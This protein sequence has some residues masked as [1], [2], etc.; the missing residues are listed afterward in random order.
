MLG[1]VLMLA[2]LS[3]AALSIESQS[4][5]VYSVSQVASSHCTN[6]ITSYG[7]TVCT[8]A[9]MQALGEE[10]V[11]GKRDEGR[12]GFR[13]N[14]ELY[15]EMTC[16][17][18]N[19]FVLHMTHDGKPG[20]MYYADASGNILNI[21]QPQ[22]NANSTNPTKT[23]ATKY[24][25]ERH[26][27]ATADTKRGIK[28]WQCH[29]I[30]CRPNATTG[31]MRC[32][33]ASAL[34]KDYTPLSIGDSVNGS[35]TNPDSLG[36]SQTGG[37]PSVLTNP[38]TSEEEK[39]RIAMNLDESTK[40]AWGKAY[41]NED[42]VLVESEK[43]KREE[44]DAAQEALNKL[45]H[46]AQGTACG[47]PNAI[48]DAELDLLR[49]KE[50]LQQIEEQ[51]KRLENAQKFLIPEGV[52][53][54]EEQGYF[55]EYGCDRRLDSISYRLCVNS[56]QP[57]ERGLRLGYGSDDLAY[58]SFGTAYSG[59]SRSEL[60]DACRRRDTQACQILAGVAQPGGGYGP[61]NPHSQCGSSG[62]GRSGGGLF[63]II[64]SVISLFKKDDNKNNN[65]VDG[66]PKPT[67][68]ITTSPKSITSPGQSVTLSWQSQ[69]GFSA[70]LSN[71]GSVAPNGSTTVEPQKT[72]TYTLSV[73][74]YKNTQT[75]EVLSGQC[76]TQV[77]VGTTTSQG[78]DPKAQISCSPQLA[79]VGMSV[80][81]SF[82]C[83]NANTSVGTGFSTGNQMSG[84]GTPVV[85]APMLGSDNKVTYGLTCSK[86]GKTDTAECTVE[87]NKTSIVLVANPQKVE[88]GKEA[89]I[90]W[91]THGMES[92]T[93]S[94]PDL[95]GFTSENTGKTA[96]SGVAKTPA[97]TTE[98]R[99]LLSCTTKAG[100]T[101]T[102]ETKVEVGN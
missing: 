44:V 58:S 2:L 33:P 101:K 88:S 76:S 80:A 28:P 1:V 93:I 49:K 31:E 92:C 91:I 22:C 79:D 24:A 69:N 61:G 83:T 25:P 19:D 102:A 17:V 37:D 46:C 74:G 75:G 71:E 48:K 72:T 84:S 87:I 59:Y 29:L 94:S 85:G 82:A 99:F 66:V 36:V 26:C 47:D 55:D 13:V 95:S 10:C 35:I 50:E 20:V 96:V 97:L 100:G 27:A 16:Q 7:R 70:S 40:D 45:R 32:D 52:V 12:C 15:K 43:K 5:A 11:S 81:I 8:N 68:S 89:N 64:T 54:K 3:A 42:A 6:P 98:A 38:R 41:Q 18:G 34:M 9:E 86:E 14:S 30:I 77:R 63:G 23:S 4:I 53:K 62:F 56:N 57:R 78:T 65:C 51:R 60:E 39:K 67:C 90:G 21:G 73:Q